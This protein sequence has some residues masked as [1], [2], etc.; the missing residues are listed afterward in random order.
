[1]SGKGFIV[2]LLAAV[3]AAAIWFAVE[4]YWRAEPSA[5]DIRTAA[6]GRYSLNRAP[7]YTGPVAR[8][9]RDDG[10][11]LDIGIVSDM[12]QFCAHTI[13]VVRTMYDQ[14]GNGAHMHKVD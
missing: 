3:W 11:S 9:Q 5:P 14:S 4:G 7:G 1:V 10:K 8:V 12:R 2:P 13:C 6:T